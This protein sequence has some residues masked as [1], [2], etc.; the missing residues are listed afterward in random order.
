MTA[1]AGIIEN[2]SV[3]IGG[4]SAGVSGYSLDIRADEKELTLS[5]IWSPHL[6]MR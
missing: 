4:D 2:G 1:I 5:N 6:R 3:W